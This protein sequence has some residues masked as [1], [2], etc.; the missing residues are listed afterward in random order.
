MHTASC[1]ANFAE[2]GESKVPYSGDKRPT[3]D[4]AVLVDDAEPINKSDRASTLWMCQLDL[5]G[6]KT[7]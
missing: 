3:L 6:G 4:Y 2:K 5:Q 7:L 1:K